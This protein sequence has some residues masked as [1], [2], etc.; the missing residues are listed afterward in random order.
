MDDHPERDDECDRLPVTPD[1]R[2]YPPCPGEVEVCEMD[3]ERTRRA[4]RNSVNRRLSGPVGESLQPGC[5]K[6]LVLRDCNVRPEVP[7]DRSWTPPV[8]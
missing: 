2:L 5:R 6:V 7:V 1:P 4:P 8:G 3:E